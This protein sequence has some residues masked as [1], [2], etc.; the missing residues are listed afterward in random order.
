M[1][2]PNSSYAIR[3]T[4]STPTTQRDAVNH[5]VIMRQFTNVY[6]TQYLHNARD[7]W[8]DVFY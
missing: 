7:G 8:R 1:Y 2:V 5:N 6:Y 3:T 4:V